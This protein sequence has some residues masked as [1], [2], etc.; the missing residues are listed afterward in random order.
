MIGKIKNLDQ[1]FGRLR[2]RNSVFSID[3]KAGDPVNTQPAGKFVLRKDSVCIQIALEELECPFAIEARRLGVN[4][5]PCF[6]VNRKYA[7]S[8][9]QSPEVLIQVFDLANQ[10]DTPA[11][12]E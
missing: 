3:D 5:V 1:Y 11:N 12:S 4:G 9:A 10:D 2:T 8:G 6:I 7:V